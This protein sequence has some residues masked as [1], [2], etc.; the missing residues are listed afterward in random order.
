M[1]F[2]PPTGSSETLHPPIKSITDLET[3]QRV[4][5][6]LGDLEIT[7]AKRLMC[8]H[9]GLRSKCYSYRFDAGSTYDSGNPLEGTRHAAELGPVFQNFAG[10]G[11]PD[12]ENPFVGKSQDYMEMSR[13]MGL[14]W[15][16]F[17]SR[18]NPN[19]AF[20]GQNLW[21]ESSDRS[22]FNIVFNETLPFVVEED[23]VRRDVTDYINRIQHSVFE[24]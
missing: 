16:G 20:P 10:L 6:L 5:Q 19:A 1:S 7:A 13:R 3:Y 9:Y 24:K 11:F 18:L 21:P 17:I 15:A 8:G 22:H 14:M 23:V 2:Y 4:E 12:G